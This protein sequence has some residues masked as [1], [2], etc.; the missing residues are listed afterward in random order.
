MGYMAD[1][2]GA[3]LNLQM[4]ARALN[5]EISNG[6]VLAPGPGHSAKDRSMAV[7][8][9]SGAPDGF[10]VNSFSGD[11][12]ITCKDFVRERLNLPAFK[13]NGGRQRASSEAIE[14]MLMAVVGAQS[15]KPKAQIIAAYNYT[16]AEG[17]LLYQVL[18]LEPKDFRQ[19]RPDGNGKWI[20]KLDDQRVV[21]RWPDLLKYPD[22]T[23]FVC[24]AKKM[25]IA[26]PH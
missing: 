13:P 1:N 25:L 22:A 7:K 19:R 20:W 18:R 6:Q 26:S 12:P 16:D 11:D 2:S 3:L 4:V 15:Q 23:V 21:Y 8:I 14:R 24:E 5:G 17:K 9:D 10:L